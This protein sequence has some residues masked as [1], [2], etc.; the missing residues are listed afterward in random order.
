MSDAT[1]KRQ[2]AT[3]IV[4]ALHTNPL[5]VVTLRQLAISGGGLLND[6]IRREAWPKLLRVDVQNIPP[7]PGI[8]V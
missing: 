8:C 3:A 4:R 7:K 2:K 1:S 6:A 5:D